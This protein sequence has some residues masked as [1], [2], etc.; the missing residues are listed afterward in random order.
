[1]TGNIRNVSDRAIRYKAPQAKVIE[2]KAQQVLCQSNGNEP[3]REVDYGGG[4]FGE[5]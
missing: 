3:M 2:V 5:E 1:M 4:G